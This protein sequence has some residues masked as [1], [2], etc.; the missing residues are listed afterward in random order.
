MMPQDAAFYGFLGGAVA[1]FL[2]IY[3]FRHLV[4]REWPVYFRLPSYWV[5][6]M[7]MIGLGAGLAAVYAQSAGV[8]LTPYLA[9]NIGASA[10]LILRSL[11]RNTPPAPGTIKRD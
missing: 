7:L 8:R 3:G 5:L 2:G 6:T 9:G 4:M 10:P 1:E 11:T